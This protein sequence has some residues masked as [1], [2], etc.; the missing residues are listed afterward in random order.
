MGGKNQA[1]PVNVDSEPKGRIS[2]RWQIF[3]IWYLL[4]CNP[5]LIEK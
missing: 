4:L 3:L 1:I 5:K 2:P